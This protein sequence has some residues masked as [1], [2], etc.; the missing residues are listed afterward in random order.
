M[1][2][3]EPEILSADGDIVAVLIAVRSI[4]TAEKENDRLTVVLKYVH[5]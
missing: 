3:A 5:P 1:A 4:T 2:E